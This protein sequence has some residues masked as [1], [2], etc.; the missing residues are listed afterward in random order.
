MSSG[1]FRREVVE[2]QGTTWLGGI[3]LAQPLRLWLLASCALLAAATVSTFLILGEYTR[4]STVAGRLVPDLGLSTVVSPSNG[5][6]SRLFPEEGD[7]VLAGDA[8]TV[9]QMPRSISSGSDA[10]VVIRKGID[11]RRESLAELHRSQ[12]ALVGAQRDGYARQLAAAR[13]ELTQIER[14]ILTRKE[15]VRIGN[16][17]IDRYQSVADEKYVS[18]VQLNQQRQSVLDMLNA[19]QALERQ[20]TSVRRNIAQL[21]QAVNELPAQE[22]VLQATA[23][24]D[25]SLLDQERVDR[26]ANGELLIK[27]PVAGL[28]TTRLIETGEPVQ[29]GQPI[30]SVL[31]KGS[32]LRAQLLVPSRSIG[33]VKPGDRVLLRYQAFPYQKFGRHGGS[34]V[35][36]SRS[37]LTSPVNGQES[38]EPYYRVM[39]ELDRQAVIAYG[40]SEFLR[41]GMTLEADILGERRRLYEW[42]LEPLYSLRGRVAN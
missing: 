19:Q 5:V 26:E 39:V 16:E 4:R 33:F 1:L 6:V 2:A 34:V 17:T 29:V 38:S 21:Q 10:L 27:A 31:P 36:V 9:I 14:E 8:L 15:Q 28:V 13:K 20:A 37:A 41:P 40:K 30:M 18:Q 3:S 22:G 12:L 7:E 11:D 42:V 25:R 23:R 35:R 32:K 24:R